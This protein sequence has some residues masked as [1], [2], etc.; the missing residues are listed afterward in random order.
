MTAITFRSVSKHFGDTVAL[1]DVSAELAAGAVTALVGANGAGKSTLLRVLLGLIAPTSGSAEIDG[2]AY[3]E[4]AQP[5]RLAGAVLEGTGFHPGRTGR[6]HLRMLARAAGIPEGRVEEVLD[7]V[8]LSGVS[9][10]RVGGYSFGMRQRLALAAG[11]LGKP[12]VLVLDEP[13]TGLDPPGIRWLRRFL[14]DFAARGNTALVSSHALAEVVLSA[15]RIMVL[16]RGRL[17]AHSSVEELTSARTG[18]E[19]SFFA[20]IDNEEPDRRK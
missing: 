11:L 8:D 17:M 18:L 13:A 4:L 15:D 7:A 14:R 20:L 10:K 12:R 9:S 19:D 5:T 3:R 2:S 16:H 1:D 6:D